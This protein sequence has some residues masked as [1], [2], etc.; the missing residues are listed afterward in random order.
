ML[1]LARTKEEVVGQLGKYVSNLIRG[2]IKIV[3][4]TRSTEERIAM[5]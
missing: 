1:P 4:R 2:I 5:R 3:T